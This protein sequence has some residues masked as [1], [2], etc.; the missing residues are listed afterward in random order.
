MITPDNKLRISHYRPHSD[1]VLPSADSGWLGPVNTI[2]GQVPGVNFRPRIKMVRI[3]PDNVLTTAHRWQYRCRPVGGSWDSWVFFG[4]ATDIVRTFDTEWYE[5]Q[6]DQ[7]DF[8]LSAS[9]LI[10]S[11]GCYVISATATASMSWPSAIGY[12]IESEVCCQL[13][14]EDVDVGDSIQF[15]LVRANG[16]VNDFADLSTC[17]LIVINVPPVPTAISPSSGSV[18]GGTPV[19]ISGTDFVEGATVSVGGAACTEV[20]R[21]SSTRLTAVTAEHTEGLVDVVVQNPTQPE[22][23]MLAN[24]FTYIDIPIETGLFGASIRRLRERITTSANISSASTVSAKIRQEETVSASLRSSPTVSARIREGKTVSISR[25]R[26][27][28]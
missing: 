24:A 13:I 20:V 19:A 2:W 6:D 14:P 22:V 15:R 25:I 26:S 23:G 10:A 9:T 11:N 12:G 1:G 7:L 16:A 21:L 17:E 4:T 27:G 18:S 5:H 8:L 3:S 28:S